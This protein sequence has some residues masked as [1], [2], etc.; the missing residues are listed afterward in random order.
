M[1]IHWPIAQILSILHLVVPCHVRLIT[2]SYPLYLYTFR[3]CLSSSKIC[4]TVPRR[5]AY[6]LQFYTCLS[7]RPG[8]S[9]LAAFHVLVKASQALSGAPGPYVALATWAVVIHIHEHLQTIGQARTQTT[10]ENDNIFQIYLVQYL[11]KIDQSI[12]KKFWCI[13]LK[14]FRDQILINS[15]RKPFQTFKQPHEIVPK[16]LQ[17]P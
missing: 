1:F 14:R 7:T 10:S 17:R 13:S 8:S 9:C 5:A 11:W 15:C 12:S 16:P 3:S 2:Q 6:Y 4:I